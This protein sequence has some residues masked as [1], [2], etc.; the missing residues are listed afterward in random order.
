[1]AYIT[2]SDYVDEAKALAQDTEG[3][4]YPTARYY[5]AMNAGLAEAWRVRPDFYRGLDTPPTYNVS[6]AN[7]TIDFPRQY[8]WALLFYIVGHLEFTDE[9]GNLDQRAAALTTAFIAKLTKAGA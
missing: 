2:G 3:V 1:M 8:A 6:D 9:E 7:T 4:R 5:Q